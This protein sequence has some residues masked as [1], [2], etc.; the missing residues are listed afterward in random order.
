MLD[1]GTGNDTY[2]FGQG[3]GQDVLSSYDGTAGKQDLVQFK[4]G[5][6]AADVAVSRWGDSLTLRIGNTQDQLTIWNYFYNDGSFNP[7]GI[8]AIRFDDGTSW[9]DADV[10]NILPGP[11]TGGDALYGYSTNDVLYGL[12]GNDY[13]NGRGGDDILD[14]GS[15]NDVMDGGAGDDT[16]LIGRGDGQDLISSYDG[17]Q[18]KQDVV[19]FK[20]GV[21]ATDVV[22][23]RDGD[24]LILKIANPTS[25]LH[26]ANY[27]L[28]SS[29]APNG[30]GSDQLTIHNYFTLDG[31]F[32]PYGIEAIRFDD[33][34]SWGYTEI[35]AK[36]LVATEGDDILYGFNSADVIHGRSGN[37]T[38]Y[39][40]GGNDTLDGGLGNDTINGDDGNDILR[41]N[42]GNDVLSDWNRAS[43]MDGG[44]GDD[45]LTAYDAA[46][47]LVG[48]TGNDKIQAFAQDSVVA[49]NRGDG[50]DQLTAGC[51]SMTLSLGGGIQISDL[52]LRKES[53]TYVLSMGGGDQVAIP[54]RPPRA[55]T[56]SSTPAPAATAHARAGMPHSSNRSSVAPSCV[57]E[58]LI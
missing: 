29:A 18:N 39:G 1:G 43:F 42:A 49:F 40:Q 6:A 56:P 55:S 19:Q 46:S 32:N 30:G 11:T 17:N 25:N 41:G 2:L 33:G 10:K 13:L 20:T 14:G 58:N 47:L 34:T 45:S 8:E 4:A 12:A 51:L 52:E 48:G 5:V 31:S 36:T 9:N 24:S 53:D 7:Y 44:S 26:V 22:V 23:S 28:T 54:P 57:I 16:Y 37:D 38:L 21:T 3:D 27:R 15:G 35:K 50:V